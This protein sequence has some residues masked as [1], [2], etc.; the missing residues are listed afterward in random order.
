MSAHAVITAVA[1]RTASPGTLVAYRDVVRALQTN[2]ARFLALG[3]YRRS[4]YVAKDF[5]LRR[6][7]RAAMAGALIATEDALELRGSRSE[8]ESVRGVRRRLEWEVWP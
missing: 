5:A 4:G 8:R 2:Y 1:K 3:L 7:A 6:A